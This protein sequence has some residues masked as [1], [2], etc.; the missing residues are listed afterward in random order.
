M[1]KPIRELKPLKI[2]KRYRPKLTIEIPV[3]PKIIPLKIISPLIKPME[4]TKLTE[5]DIDFFIKKLTKAVLKIEDMI[6][7]IEKVVK[8]LEEVRE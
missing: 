2:P 7:R 5:K 6:K 4:M 8:N 1:I 3:P